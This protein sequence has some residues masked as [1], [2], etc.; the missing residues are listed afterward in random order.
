[1]SVKSLLEIPV[2]IQNFKLKNCCNHH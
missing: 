2:G 1:V